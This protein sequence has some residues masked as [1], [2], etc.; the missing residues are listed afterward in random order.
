MIS[1]KPGMGT[2]TAQWKLT[3]QARFSMICH[4]FDMDD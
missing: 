3:A 1:I 4:V 2:E